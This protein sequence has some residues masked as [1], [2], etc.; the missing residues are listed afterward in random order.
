LY[1]NKLYN[2]FFCKHPVAPFI[3]SN[4]RPIHKRHDQHTESV[5]NGGRD[6]M[7]L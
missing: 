4:Y 7:I 2:T 5:E 6:Y 3:N 1:P